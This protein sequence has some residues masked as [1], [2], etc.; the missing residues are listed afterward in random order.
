[1]QPTLGQPIDATAQ[2][3]A[4]HV[5]IAPVVAPVDLQPGQHVDA[6]GNLTPPHVG[7][8]DPFRTGTICAGDRFYLCLYPNTVTSLRHEWEH[9]AFKDLHASEKWLRNYVRCNCPYD[10]D[11]SDGG[12]GKFLRRVRDDHEIFYHGS[13]CHS[14]GEVEQADELFEHLSVVLGMKVDE[15]WFATSPNGDEWHS[16]YSCSC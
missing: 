2:R 5:A 14:L 16:G 15:A 9:P 6:R 4:I 7:I 13:D 12:Y 10:A 8:V 11:E 3:D 1:M